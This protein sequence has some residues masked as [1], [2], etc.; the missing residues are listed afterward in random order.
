MKFRAFFLLCIMC[1]SSCTQKP[2][3]WN[4]VGR[5][6]FMRMDKSM[7]EYK[8]DH[9]WTKGFNDGCTTGMAGQ[10]GGILRVNKPRIDGWK[11][12]GRDP[13]NP[14]KPHPEIKNSTI[15][16]KGWWDGYE[17]CTYQYD[18]WVL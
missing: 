8:G 15:Y 10:G 2:E 11:L 3:G 6:Y 9:D 5:P 17:H 4:A 12:T 1:F 13:K 16:G 18:W 14:E 7:R